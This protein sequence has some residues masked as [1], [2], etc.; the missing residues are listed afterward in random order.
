MVPTGRRAAIVMAVLALAAVLAAV[1]AGHESILEGWWI[2]RL[3]SSDRSVRDV[4]AERLGERRSV[5][6]IGPLLEAWSRSPKIEDL[7]C[8]TPLDAHPCADALVKIG[9]PAVPALGKALL[10]PSRSG[11]AAE[12]LA[13]IGGDEAVAAL[14]GGL[15]SGDARVRRDAAWGL[16]LLGQSSKA[17]IPV[18]ERL[19]GDADERV[20]EM[21]A[22]ALAQ[23]RGGSP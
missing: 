17:A 10:D 2:W 20:G 23:V 18:L 11:L 21:A 8:W 7:S 4:A 15:Q 3:G 13:G 12:A 6:A 22:N 19:L 5:R 14:I 16:G 9:A 1:A